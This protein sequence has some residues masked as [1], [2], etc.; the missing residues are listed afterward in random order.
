MSARAWGMVALA[1]VAALVG[2]LA[3]RESRRPLAYLAPERVRLA[4][5]RPAGGGRGRD[6][7]AAETAELC[8]LLRSAA[9]AQAPPEAGGLAVRL[10]TADYGELEVVWLGGP[11]A[12]LVVDSGG[13][14]E[15]RGAVRSAALGVFLERLGKPPAGAAGAE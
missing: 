14:G 2:Y 9:R 13:A 1:A 3:W 15:R 12:R 11:L 4:Q 7:S 5:V 8:R 10:D 6:L